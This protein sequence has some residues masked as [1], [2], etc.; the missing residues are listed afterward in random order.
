MIT[1]LHIVLEA[2]LCRLFILLAH[3]C[4]CVIEVLHRVG[5]VIHCNTILVCMLDVHILLYI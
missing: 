2:V 5:D 3:E 4:L 1:A